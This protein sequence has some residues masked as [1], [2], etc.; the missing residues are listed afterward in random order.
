MFYE[1]GYELLWLGWT[2]LSQG[3]YLNTIMSNTKTTI[4]I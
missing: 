4:V 1:F 2:T 3:N